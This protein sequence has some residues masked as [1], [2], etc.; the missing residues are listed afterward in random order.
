MLEDITTPGP[1]FNTAY[2]RNIGVF[3]HIEK[4]QE[5]GEA[6]LYILRYPWGREGDKLKG[7]RPKDPEFILATRDSVL[8]TFG[9]TGL[10]SLIEKIEEDGSLKETL[11]RDPKGYL[12]LTRKNLPVNGIFD[13]P[14]LT[15][16]QLISLIINY[17]YN[18]SNELPEDKHSILSTLFKWDADKFLDRF[19]DFRALKSEK[20]IIPDE[21]DLTVHVKLSDGC[22][23]ACIYCPEGGNFKPKSMEQ[24]ME[25]L[26]TTKAIQE[27]YHK[28]TLDR[29]VE[30][31]LNTSDLF[32]F[33]EPRYRYL[34][35]NPIRLVKYFKKTFPEVEKLGTFLSVR[36]IIRMKN[37]YMERFK[38]KGATYW[39]LY[40][41]SWFS[42]LKNAG[43]N[44]VYIGIETAH[45]KGSKLLGKP[46]T[47]N[48]KLYA[49]KL[50]KDCGIAVK[51]IIQVGVL[52]Q[53]FYPLGKEK[54]EE[55]YV[56]SKEAIQKTIELIN[57]AQ[58]YRVMFSE[59]IPYNGLKI[60]KYIEDGRIIPY[61]NPRAG[62]KKELE[63][64]NKGIHLQRGRG[65]EFD[66]QE[67]LP[68][69]NKSKTL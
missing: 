27:K 2:Q 32:L 10:V 54:T 1:L 48:D 24:I 21:S 8:A 12:R 56:T 20:D 58:P 44:R 15:N 52:G 37:E 63:M 14:D 29:M 17:V 61:D 22:P 23:Y 65:K 40:L 55:S 39:E 43:L 5:T 19:R 4:I 38:K 62:I 51:A 28:K 34:G 31:F 11:R 68:E 36:N 6:E 41:K 18:K 33:T 59:F 26:K 42:E 60:F 67:F 45:D 64:L 49:I 46:D 50:L 69:N 53:G 25:D 35:V 66:Y 30:G 7:D 13:N 16:S 57:D 47:Y 3:G 9:Q